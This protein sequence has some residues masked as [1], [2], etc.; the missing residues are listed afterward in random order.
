MP[1]YLKYKEYYDQKTKATPLKEN[2]YC[3]ILQPIANTR[4]QKSHSE[5]LGGADLILLKKSCR[6]TT[7]SSETSAL[8]KG[9]SYIE[10]ANINLK[11]I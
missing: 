5:N 6:T 1:S 8:I 11:R 10:F 4:D 2:D 3:F 7:T 9:R